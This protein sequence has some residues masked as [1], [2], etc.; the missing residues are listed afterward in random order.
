MSCVHSRPRPVTATVTK[1]KWMEPKVLAGRSRTLSLDSSGST[2]SLVSVLDHDSYD[3]YESENEPEEVYEKVT[4]TYEHNDE[5]NEDKNN[6]ADD[7]SIL[8]PS[9]DNRSEDVSKVENLMHSLTTE[10]NDGLSSWES[11]LI[12]KTKLQRLKQKEM[13]Q[14]KKKEKQEKE[15]EANI[16]ALNNIKAEEKRKYGLKRKIMKKN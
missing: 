14:K 6:I 1:P 2:S 12:R 8:S 13:I 3:S 15:E 16:K 7:Y 9:V 11:W 5:H 4:L 10:D